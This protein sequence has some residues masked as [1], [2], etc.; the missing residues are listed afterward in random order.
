MR[1]SVI[2]LLLGRDGADEIW[3][4]RYCHSFHDKENIFLFFVFTLENHWTIRLFSIHS[5]DSPTGTDPIVILGRD[6]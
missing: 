5:V 3:T 1:F 6:F 2:F 4:H